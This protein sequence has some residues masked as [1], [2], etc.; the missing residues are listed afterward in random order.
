MIKEDKSSFIDIETSLFI[1]CSN[2]LTSLD[3]DFAISCFG[4]TV[5]AVSPTN[6]ESLVC[7]C[8][9][10]QKYLG[11]MESPSTIYNE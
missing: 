8:F 1:S 5:V 4:K 7:Y 6:I 11:T 10:A 2:T 3:S 9:E